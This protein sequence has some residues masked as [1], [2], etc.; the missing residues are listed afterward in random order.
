MGGQGSGLG[1]STCSV[2][3]R[4]SLYLSNP[5]IPPLYR[6]GVEGN[7]INKQERK[8]GVLFSWPGKN[9]SWSHSRFKPI[10]FRLPVLGSLLGS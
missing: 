10:S 3:L 5:Q 2:N 1:S 8:G 4:R 9:D 6:A 7:S